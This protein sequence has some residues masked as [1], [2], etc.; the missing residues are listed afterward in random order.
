MQYSMYQFAIPTFIH[1][2][3]N[4]EAILE[5]AAA[6]AAAHSAPSCSSLSLP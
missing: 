6:H 2:L 3:K 5:K 1:M 4:L